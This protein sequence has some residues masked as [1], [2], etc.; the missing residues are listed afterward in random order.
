MNRIQ[1]ALRMSDA[2]SMAYLQL[3]KETDHTKKRRNRDRKQ[4][5]ELQ[6]LLPL[7]H[8]MIASLCQLSTCPSTGLSHKKW[9]KTLGI[10]C[11]I[12][13]CM[14]RTDVLCPVLRQVLLFSFCFCLP[15]LVVNRIAAQSNKHLTLV[16]GVSGSP[17]RNQNPDRLWFI[18]WVR[19]SWVLL[20]CAIK[21]W[22][23]TSIEAGW[24]NCH[25]NG[26]AVAHDINVIYTTSLCSV[27]AGD[28]CFIC[29]NSRHAMNEIYLLMFS[30]FR[31]AP[32]LFSFRVLYLFVFQINFQC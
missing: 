3:E 17:K 29:Q 28:L 22:Y 27:S 32:D 25:L 2:Y 1:R 18:V 30:I 16:R 4:M 13:F 7:L 20:Q 5:L 12:N 10:C 31:H 19:I 8:V 11:I 24:A 21:P 15:K 9:Y 6:L 14:L 23:C 26:I